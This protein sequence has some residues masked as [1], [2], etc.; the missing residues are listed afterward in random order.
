M[1]ILILGDKYEK[2][3]KSQGSQ[4]LISYNSKL[5][6]IDH[7]HNTLQEWF[8]KANIY[9][10]YGLGDKKFLSYYN[11]NKKLGTIGIVYNPEYEIKNDVYSVY[12]C[13]ENVLSEQLLIIYGNSS[14]KKNQIQKILKSQKSSIFRNPDNTIS[15]IGCVYQNNTVLNIAYDLDTKIS[16]MYYICKKDMDYFKSAI[17]NHN[18]HNK[19]L[20]EIFNMMIDEKISIDLL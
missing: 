13:K 19:F 9:Y 15:D 4:A 2:G 5:K 6:Y 14:I 3:K 20:F 8:P 1:N 16:N 17:Y 10:V 18:H 11:N 7:Q 12:L